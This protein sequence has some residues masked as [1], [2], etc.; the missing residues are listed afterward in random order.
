MEAN[1]GVM[2]RERLWLWMASECH[3][4]SADAYY[5][6]KQPPSL[7][8]PASVVVFNAVAQISSKTSVISS[9]VTAEHSIY[10]SARISWAFA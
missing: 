2:R 10:L 8:P 3:T 7:C 9:P 6:N 1:V 5:I 4:E